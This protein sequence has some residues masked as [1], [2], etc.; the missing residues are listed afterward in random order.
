MVRLT[1]DMYDKQRLLLYHPE[2]NRILFSSV[3]KYGHRVPNSYFK[4]NDKK[5]Y[6]L[7]INENQGLKNNLYKVE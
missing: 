2:T 6:F 1:D 7:K 3:N 4:P 5:K